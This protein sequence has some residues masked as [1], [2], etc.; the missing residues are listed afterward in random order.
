MW[1]REPT[2]RSRRSTRSHGPPAPSSGPWRCSDVPEGGYQ[3]EA[4]VGDQVVTSTYVEVGRILK[5]A[6][7]LDVV[8]GHRVYVA[9]DRIKVTATA[10]FYEGTPVPGVPL[11]V[12]GLA[13]RT[14]STDA[15]GTAI[16]PTTATSL[17]GL[18]I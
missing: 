12:S 4:L 3:V 2:L 15:T 10:R 1:T 16:D 9:G 14:A 13:D 18:R 5:P 17:T 6:Y 8:T 7:R 11:R